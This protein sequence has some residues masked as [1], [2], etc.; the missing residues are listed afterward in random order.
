MLAAGF[1]T[2]FTRLPSV[3]SVVV[4]GLFSAAL[5]VWAIPQARRGALS[6][7]VRLRRAAAD[8]LRRRRANRW[9]VLRDFGLACVGLVLAL[10]GIAGQWAA[11]ALTSALLALI[12]GILIAQLVPTL[13]G[14]LRR[15]A[16]HALRG[17]GR[18]VRTAQAPLPELSEET[19]RARRLNVLRHAVEIVLILAVIWDFT[20]VLRVDA[21]EMRLY[22][23]E[24]EY[25]TASAYT[26][27]MYLHTYG[28]I[29]LWQPWLEHGEP[30]VTGPFSF[31]LNPISTMPSLI[32]N[33]VHGLKLSV[34]LYTLLAGLGGWVLGLSLGLGTVGRVLLGLLMAG[35]GSMHAPLSAGF[36]QLASSQA[37]MPWIVFA[38]LATFRYKDRRWPPVLLAV[39]ITL[40]LWA[41]NLWYTLPMVIT[42]GLL[43]LVLLV[44]LPGRR[45]DWHAIGRLA[46][47]AALTLGLSAI[48]LIPMWATRAYILHPEEKG[49]GP[50]VPLA[51]LL[52]FYVRPERAGELLPGGIAT[53]YA[54]VVPVWFLLLLFVYIPPVLPTFFTHP[55]RRDSWRIWLVGGS[56]IVLATL[57]A[58]GGTPLFDWLYAHI[59][60]LREWRFTGRALA[61]GAFW[62]AVL[63]AMRAD[64]I[65]H[66]L[67]SPAWRQRF[68][69]LILV[70]AVLVIAFG[71]ACWR[72]ARQVTTQWGRLGLL[73]ARSESDETCIGWLRA[74]HPGE[75]LSV[76]RG[77]YDA[78]YAFLDYKVRLFNVEV[79]YHALPRSSILPDL[80]LRA[81]LPQYGVVWIED[82]RNYLIAHGFQPVPGSPR[83]AEDQPCAYSQRR[84]YPYAF[85]VPAQ[86]VPGVIAPELVTPLAV[87]DRKPDHIRLDVLAQPSQSLIVVVDEL[88]FP[89]WHARIDGQRVRVESIGGLI[90]VVVPPL[91]ESGTKQRITFDFRPALFVEC[92]WITLAVIAF[93][94]LYLLRAERVL[95]RLRPRSHLTSQNAKSSSLID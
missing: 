30:L 3:L 13:P 1:L 17:A 93:C 76:F 29:P 79:A 58:M 10:M 4:F 46:F 35:R 94:V 69:W 23:K 62:I 32:T 39:T 92:A 24:G 53:F 38:A 63:V 91:S 83:P 64:A 60:L 50:H 75:E 22:G 28:Y 86:L 37:Y 82:V 61:I 33:G 21:P 42:V 55:A 9:I 57:W 70:Q 90:G 47:A 5:W 25:L 72:A 14:R 74:E 48:T 18:A 81:A 2:L 84:A 12:T 59:V 34:V 52:R 41:G 20:A 65:A 43:A 36:F 66:F 54:F 80:N 26:A 19:L 44:F 6:L 49:S 88:A 27:S 45:I 51:T 68:R 15:A 8:A 87:T 73:Y 95:K 31:V 56:L 89:G 85:A 11:L 71:A 77:D 78:V 40:L 16:W 7:G 67:T